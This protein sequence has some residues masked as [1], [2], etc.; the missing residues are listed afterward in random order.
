M[1]FLANVI[2]PEL[3]GSTREVSYRERISGD[4]YEK[5]TAMNESDVRIAFG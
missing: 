5:D 3:Y 4:I 1:S 2:R